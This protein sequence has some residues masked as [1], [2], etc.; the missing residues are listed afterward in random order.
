MRLAIT[1][2]SFYNADIYCADTRAAKKILREAYISILAIDYYLVGQGNGCDLI[3]WA[4]QNY[5]LPDFVVVIERDR[6]KRVIL[7]DLL[8]KTG[9]QS[10]DETTFIKC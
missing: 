2:S 3:R 9:Y 7:S 8:R 10:S 4:V 6:N 1:R 5:V